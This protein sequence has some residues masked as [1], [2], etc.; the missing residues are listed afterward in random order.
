[1]KLYGAKPA[2]IAFYA[3]QRIAALYFGYRWGHNYKPG[4]EGITRRE[5]KRRNKRV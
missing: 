4:I 3:R 2:T 1:M 5:W